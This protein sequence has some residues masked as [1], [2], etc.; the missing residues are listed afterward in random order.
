MLERPVPVMDEPQ[1]VRPL[2]PALFVIFVGLLYCSWVVPVTLQR[3]VGTTWL[4]FG[5]LN[6]LLHRR[7]GRQSYYW[8]RGDRFSGRWWNQIGEQGA[9]ALYLGI[10]VIL[11]VVGC[12]LLLSSFDLWRRSG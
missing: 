7:L 8:T 12:I 4:L 9:Q 3:F 5:L 1:A 2:A 6:V 11:V 10:G